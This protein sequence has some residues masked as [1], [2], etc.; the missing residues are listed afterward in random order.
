MVFTANT[1]EQAY[2]DVLENSTHNEYV[3][4]RMT[5]T[6]LQKSIIDASEPL[7]MLLK[8]NLEIDY[9]TMEQGSENGLKDEVELLTNGEFVTKEVSFYRPKTKSGDPR[10]WIYSLKKVLEAFDL[11]LL[12]V[13]D[14]KLYAIP[15]KG[16]IEEFK[17]TLSTIFKI[18]A[19]NLPE[20]VLELQAKTKELFNRGYIKTMRG[21]DTGIGFTFESLLGIVANSSKEPDYKGVEIKCSRQNNTTLQT[22]FA[23]TP[24][25]AKLSNKRTSLVK[26]YGY[27]DDENK[28]Y[29]L[30]I[31]I[32]TIQE[33]S[34][35]WQLTID[36]E[37]QK[38]YVTKNGE[39]VVYYDY[40]TLRD[41]LAAKHKQTVFIK[42]L[43]ENRKSKND[44]NETFLYESALY[45]EDSSFIN[46]MSLMEM[47]NVSLDFAIHHDPETGKTRDH[48]FLWRI[49]KQHIPTLFKR[50][51]KLCIK[52]TDC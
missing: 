24:N 40:K 47:G 36:S 11:L 49:G 2:I 23:K 14:G 22:L 45:C 13:W 35:G 6:M 17:H 28:R 7:R 41:A 1:N 46:F 30:Y 48:G 34:K 44:V 12:T 31:T 38:I 26:D 15:L 29:A 39:R 3:L 42:A 33:N 4:I 51:V 50:Q 21:G 25:Y 16:D 43:S 27:W 18:D 19:D 37:T 20:A 9:V 32:N 10:F 52:D 8:E 5:P